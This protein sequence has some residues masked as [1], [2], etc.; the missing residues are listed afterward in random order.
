MTLRSGKTTVVAVSLILELVAG[1]S[2]SKEDQARKLKQEKASWEATAQLTH[3]VSG[4]GALSE[5][6]TRELLQK[7]REKLAQIR[8]QEARLS[9]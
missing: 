6:Y 8:D 9:R 5:T 2:G 3:E 1:C 4:R 7:V